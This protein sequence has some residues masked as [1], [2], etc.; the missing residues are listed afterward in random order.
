[1]LPVSARLRTHLASCLCAGLA[2]CSFGTIDARAADGGTEAGT[3][4]VD[5][6]Q[7]A[8]TECKTPP[9]PTRLDISSSQS[10]SGD[11]AAPLALGWNEVFFSSSVCPHPCTVLGTD[12]AVGSDGTIW[13]LAEAA[14]TGTGAGLWLANFERDGTIQRELMVTWES[15]DGELRPTYAAKLAIDARGRLFVS[16]TQAM[17]PDASLLSSDDMFR[18][19]VP[20]R[21]WIAV[22]EPDGTLLERTD[23][24]GV[25]ERGTDVLR[26]AIVSGDEAAALLAVA[27][28]MS[29][30]SAVSS[31]DASLT[32]RWTHSRIPGTISAIAATADGGA[33]VLRQQLSA[34]RD[35]WV[36]VLTGLDAAGNVAWN[37][38]IDVNTEVTGFA[39]DSFG[40]AFVSGFTDYNPPLHQHFVARL[41]GDGTRMWAV[42]LPDTLGSTLPMTIDQD[43]TLFALHGADSGD[44]A[45]YEIAPDAK[46]CVSHPVTFD[47]SFFTPSRL[48]ARAGELWVTIGP[49]VGHLEPS[50]P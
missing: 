32:R 34:T 38:S 36:N 18:D 27:R 49:G 16:V 48:L 33:T 6:R 9:A 4:D 17:R 41:T 30:I 28:P 7:C 23:V 12:A 11:D 42:G 8:N 10:C 21:A 47:G 22:Y 1:M 46:S 37:R 14:G 2:A 5:V 29:E 31:F 39:G 3:G 24:G 50:K 45:I 40:Y 19:L 26:P 20:T 43:G 13:L 15:G 35:A 44:A 25:E